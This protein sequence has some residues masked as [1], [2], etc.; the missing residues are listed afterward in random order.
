[1]LNKL[2]AFG[3]DGVTENQISVLSPY[4]A[5]CHI[6]EKEL[7]ASGISKVSVTSIV[8]SQGMFFLGGGG[9]GGGGGGRSG[10]GGGIWIIK[11]KVQ[12]LPFQG[13]PCQASVIGETVD[14][15]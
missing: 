15:V 7:A 9:G 8:K 10:G 12:C 6:I 14:F 11:L 13:W 1:M 3:K 2:L 5:Q 4:R